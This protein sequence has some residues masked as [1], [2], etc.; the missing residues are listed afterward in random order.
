[1]II[2]GDRGSQ[3]A[4]GRARPAA[5]RWRSPHGVPEDRNEDVII[6]AAADAC[7]DLSAALPEA[8]RRD[9][10]EYVDRLLAADGPYALGTRRA[11]REALARAIA[12]RLTGSGDGD[13]AAGD[14]GALQWGSS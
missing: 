9:V 11:A 7:T 10:T 8:V 13:G 12:A 2:G 4:A 6:A 5:D 1:M 14:T 3:R